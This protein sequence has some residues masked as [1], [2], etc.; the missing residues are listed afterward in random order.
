MSLYNMLHG[1]HGLDQVL[2]FVLDLDVAG[3]SYDT[4]RYRD[5]WLQDGKIYLFT[6]NGGGN[7]EEYQGVIDDLSE[8]SNYIE[9]YDDDFDSTYAT[10]VFSYP[11]HYA[12]LL[13][14]IEPK[15]KE[16]SL[17]EKTDLAIES[18]GKTIPEATKDEKILKVVENLLAELR[19][20]AEPSKG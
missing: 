9:D 11:E 17:K 4:G 18:I 20:E 7:R 12:A 1:T 10:I 6:R 3:G 15:E 16:P 14:H 8:H 2:G 19:N 13:K 5:I